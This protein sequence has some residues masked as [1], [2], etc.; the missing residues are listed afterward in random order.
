MHITPRFSVLFGALALLPILA[1]ADAENSLAV[2]QTLLKQP[3]TLTSTQMLTKV[4]RVDFPA[5]YKTPLHTHEGQG[6]RYIV[7]GHIKIEDHGKSQVYG[8]G[9][10]FWETGDEMTVENIGGSDAE[11]IIFEIAPL[12]EQPA[13]K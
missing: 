6:P 9:E 13:L 3:V 1:Q 11:F 7:K 5:G 4:I 12:T 8:P 2:R 10:V